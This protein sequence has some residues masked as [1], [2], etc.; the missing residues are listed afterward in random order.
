MEK[1]DMHNVVKMA[2]NI[3]PKMGEDYCQTTFGTSLG[4][5]HSKDEN[6]AIV[7]I[8]KDFGD[9]DAWI[10]LYKGEKSEWNW[11][12]KTGDDIMKDTCYYS[13]W[14]SG[15]PQSAEKCA[16]IQHFGEWAG[17]YVSFFVFSHRM[18]CNA[19]HII[20][21]CVRELLEL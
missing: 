5:V 1:T 16:R 17:C 19:C 15:E 12:D 7:Q 4:S 8:L 21:R 9:I 6:D 20:F 13:N 10:G 18:Q 11:G 14:Q 3:S 2:R